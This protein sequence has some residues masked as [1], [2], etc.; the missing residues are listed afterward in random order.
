MEKYELTKSVRKILVTLLILVVCV[1]IIGILSHNPTMA[2]TDGERCSICQTTTIRWTYNSQVHGYYC[3]YC[4]DWY[5]EA[6]HNNVPVDYIKTEFYM[7]HTTYYVC[8]EEGCDYKTQIT[9]DCELVNFTNTDNEKHEAQCKN[10]RDIYI[11]PHVDSDK[12]GKCDD[13]NATYSSSGGKCDVCT[14]YVEEYRKKDEVLHS[15]YRVCTVCGNEWF[16][17]DYIHKFE[18][19]KCTLCGQED[20]N[21]AI[22]INSTKYNIN[23]GYI[24]KVQPSTKV[25]DFKSKINTNATQIN[26]Y[27]NTK[28]LS[29]NE[30]IATGMKLELKNGSKTL[31]YTLIVSGDVNSDGIADF[32]DLVKIN[33]SR[34]NKITL[35]EKYLL[36]SDVNQDGKVDLKDLTKINRFRLCKIK[37]L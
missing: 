36:A 5:G 9:E 13:C 33:K 4:A 22:E 26:V 25:S 17:A 1:I 19:G 29:S 23:D 10:C 12:N 2:Y 20:T 30:K 14:S 37:E 3:D 18:N 16:D 32:K 28:L 7:T 31:T 21:C 35:E 6:S 27:N 34:L 11:L 15:C 8:T 24:L